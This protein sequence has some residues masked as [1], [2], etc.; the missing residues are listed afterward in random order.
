MIDSDKNESDSIKSMALKGNTAKDVT[1]RF[2]KGEML[3]FAKLSL[4]SFVYDLTDIFCFSTEEVRNIYDQHDII[5]CHMY[6]NL[7]YTNSCSFF[8]NFICKKECNNNK[9][10]SRKLIFEILKHSKILKF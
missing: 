10:E 1:S 3:M 2:I 5:K 4:K 7:T 9:S 6:L 8:E